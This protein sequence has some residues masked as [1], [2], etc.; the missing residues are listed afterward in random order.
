M[1]PGLEDQCEC[2]MTYGDHLVRRG[3]EGR[4]AVCPDS[5][6]KRFAHRTTHDVGGATATISVHLRLLPSEY[7][8][9]RRLAEAEGLAM[10]PYLRELV[11]F[12]AGQPHKLDLRRR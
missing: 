6:L 11:R 1:I 4:R 5:P 9:L 3:P 7:G 10:S 8:T 2:G 12:A